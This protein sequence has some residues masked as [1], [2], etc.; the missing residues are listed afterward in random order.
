VLY[1]NCQEGES[2][3]I[4]R[5]LKKILKTLLTNSKIYD[6]IRMS[7]GKRKVKK[8]QVCA[9]AIEKI[10]LEKPKKVLDKPQTL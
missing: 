10:S 1:Y 2:R 8:L 4:N 6:I 3:E 5:A 9:L 7:K